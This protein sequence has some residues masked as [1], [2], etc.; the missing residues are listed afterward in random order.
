MADQLGQSGLTEKDGRLY[1]WYF[2][3][4]LEPLS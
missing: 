3:S 2:R 4:H 1:Q